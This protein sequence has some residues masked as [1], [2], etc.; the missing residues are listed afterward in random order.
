[1]SCSMSAF[2]IFLHRVLRVQRIAIHKNLFASLL[3]H[4][5]LTIVF[6]SVVLIPYI[7]NTGEEETTLEEVGESNC[8]L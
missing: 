5:I 1:M 6:K 7:R 3:F 2:F 8:H 4:S